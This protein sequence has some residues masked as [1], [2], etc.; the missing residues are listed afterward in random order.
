MLSYVVYKVGNDK[1]ITNSPSKESKTHEYAKYEA[2]QSIFHIYLK[3]KQPFCLFLKV[4]GTL[5]TIFFSI[6]VDDFLFQYS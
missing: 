2:S 6:L 5:T 1:V 3:I 4:R